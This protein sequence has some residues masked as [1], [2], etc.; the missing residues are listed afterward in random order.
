MNARTTTSTLFWKEEDDAS[1][2]SNVS[3]NLPFSIFKADTESSSSCLLEERVAW[4]SHNAYFKLHML[5]F[6]NIRD[7]RVARHS[8]GLRT[9]QRKGREPKRTG[10]RVWAG[11]DSDFESPTLASTQRS[12]LA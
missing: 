6:G 8:F 11:D 12:M 7:N 10:A 9:D 2:F 4:T 1:S 5:F 3:T